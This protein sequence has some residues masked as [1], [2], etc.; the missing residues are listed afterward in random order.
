MFYNPRAT[1][2][3][4]YLFLPGE[5]DLLGRYNSE[6][7]KRCWVS[8]N[9]KREHHKRASCSIIN[10][11]TNRFGQSFVCYI[12]Y[13]RSFPVRFVKYSPF[14]FLGFGFLFYFLQVFLRFVYYYFL[15]LGFWL[16]HF[17]TLCRSSAK[18]HLFQFKR[19]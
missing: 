16:S 6:P 11:L 10:E 1:K 8:A 5:N 4:L 7:R 3:V 9:D 13:C 2:V 14:S 15:P 17:A 19:F 18:K 12:V